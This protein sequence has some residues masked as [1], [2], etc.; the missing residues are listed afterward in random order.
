MF[1]KCCGIFLAVASAHSAFIAAWE[2][3][4]VK[5]DFEPGW[6]PNRAAGERGA[7]QPGRCQVGY[8]KS[9]PGAYPCAPCPSGTFAPDEGSI[10]CQRC[11][12]FD[13]MTG[14]AGGA[15]CSTELAAVNNAAAW[16]ATFVDVPGLITYAECLLSNSTG[17]TP[18]ASTLFSVSPAPAP[19]PLVAAQPAGLA[20]ET[21]VLPA[22]KLPAGVLAGKARVP[23]GLAPAPALSPLSETPASAPGPLISTPGSGPA[24]SPANIA[25]SVGKASITSLPRSKSLKDALA[26][27]P[28]KAMAP[29]AAAPAAGPAMAPGPNDKSAMAAAS[30]PLVDNGGPLP[31]SEFVVAKVTTIPP[32]TLDSKETQ[33]QLDASVRVAAAPCST[34][35]SGSQRC[36]IPIGYNDN[37]RTGTVF[38]PAN[39]MNRPIPFML[40]LH[41][42][43]WTGS[44]MINIFKP[45]AIKYD[46]AIIAPDSH[47]S[48]F[49]SSP[50]TAQDPF[51]T[52]WFHI[53][54]CWDEVMKTP[55]V[56]ANPAFLTAFGNSRASYAAIAYASRSTTNFNT[57][58][59]L[60]ASALPQQMGPRAFSILWV[61]GTLD[62]LYGPAAAKPDVVR[63]RAA[64]PDFP[65]KWEIWVDN[66][67]IRN[68][69][70][71]EAMV[72]WWLQPDTRGRF[73]Q[74]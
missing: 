55:G 23:S 56:M 59:I 1:P 49:W 60:H 42:S 48:I 69:T 47:N 44:D 16:G 63:F 7:G 14:S 12:P 71:I 4:T 35:D 73:I 17:C 43:G 57:G 65:I 11:A 36:G 53:Q 6:E 62:P 64:R 37:N 66:H 51:T 3:G 26:P 34:E 31:P 5:M 21:A 8:Y 74:T 39:H 58:A 19:G 32:P 30:G 25:P 70:E 72:T 15:F 46:Y 67:T 24:P 40:L 27:G 10:H 20:P 54:A 50:D 13:Q 61:T 52:D 38:Y 33:M 18:A 2:T 22:G 45:Y 68:F 28:Q 41:G 9:Y 29:A